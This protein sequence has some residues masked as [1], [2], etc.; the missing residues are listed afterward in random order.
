MSIKIY[1]VF[2]PND[3]FFENHWH[4]D[5]GEEKWEAYARVIREEVIAKS[6][7]FSLAENTMEEK[8]D[9]KLLVKGK[10]PKKKS[11]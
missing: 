10:N 3:Y 4:K 8:M 2:K 7:G 5:K 11:E 9:Y 1:P 6:W